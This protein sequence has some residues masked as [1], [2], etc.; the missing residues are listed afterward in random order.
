MR[1][2]QLNMNAFG[3]YSGKVS[4]DFTSF[5]GSSIFLVSG[6]TGAGKTTIF[7]ALAYALFDEA[8]GDSRDK[9]TFKSQFASDTDLCYVELEFELNGESYYIKRIP[10]QKGPGKTGK[11]I[12]RK[13]EVEFHHP[14][15]QT[16][17][18]KEANEEIE[19]LIG[20]TYEQF[21]QIVMLPQGQFKK[22]LESDSGDKEKIFRNIFKTNELEAFQKELKEKYSELRKEFEKFEH[23]LE[24][25]FK[26]I[27]I[28][29]SQ[30]LGKA[31]EQFETPQVLDELKQ[32]I[33]LDEKELD[34][35]DKQV[36]KLQKEGN[37][38]DRLITSLD[39]KNRLINELND[40]K[41]NQVLIDGYSEQLKAHE[42]AQKLSDLKKQLDETIKD[43]TKEEKTLNEN[44]QNLKVLEKQLEE[45]AAE[46]QKAETKASKLPEKRNRLADLNN[47]LQIFDR[48][49][50]VVTKKNALEKMIS[51]NKETIKANQKEENE[52][53]QE[54][55]NMEENLEKIEDWQKEK[56]NTIEKIHETDRKLDTETEYL[57]QV[58]KMKDQHETLLDSQQTMEKAEEEYKQA[59]HDY[60]K[61]KISYYNDL[62]GVLAT[63]LEV[64][65]PCPVCGSIHHPNAAG[66]S[67][68]NV[69]K[70]EY[71]HLFD[72]VSKKHGDYTQAKA[73][74]EQNAENLKIQLREFDVEASQLVEEIAKQEE[75]VQQ[76][77]DFSKELKAKRKQLETDLAKEKEWREALT[78]ISEGIQNVVKNINAARVEIEQKQKQM[79]ELEEER[80]TE[81]NKLHFDSKNDVTK[82][83][84]NV[85]KD[86]EEVEKN[87]KTSQ[88]QLNQLNNEKAS[89]DRTIEMTKQQIKTLTERKDSQRELFEEKLRKS[90]LSR[91]FQEKILEETVKED[92]KNKVDEHKEA[93]IKKQT[94]LSDQNDYLKT[95]D[96]LKSL[97]YYKEREKEIKEQLPNIQKNR[98]DV[99]NRL[100]QNQQ[101]YSEI[102]G[103]QKQSKEIEERVHTYAELSNYANGS[104]ETDYISFERYV[105]GIYFEE[106]LQAANIRFALMTNNRYLLERKIDKSKGAGPQ[107]L[108]INV[109][110][111]YTGKERNVNTLSGGETFK[112]SLSLALGLS[113]VIQSQN[114][115]VSVDTLFIDEGFGTLD[116]DSL[117][118]AIQTLLDLNK[119]GRLIGIISHVEELKTRIS[120]HII[121]EKTQVGSTAT[122]KT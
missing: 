99:L 81:T 35:L 7:D 53:L 47:E 70:E 8:S 78:Q 52:L 19:E 85:A 48:I 21:Q 83:I 115:G 1:P 36:F 73:R 72:R 105:L 50:Q 102:E 122:I 76:H 96:D 113:D 74:F 39:K 92:Y 93:L 71:D 77:E 29:G 86:I 5:Q 20:I 14:Y 82:A 23:S 69:T 75:L 112:A 107:G 12:N 101:A 9:D 2:L 45:T 100:R 114:G 65:D 38:L 97:G 26:G 116:S 30:K 108:D 6:P 109:F 121:V 16:T 90:D 111:H 61:A 42:Q 54:K 62:A 27:R 104:K 40:L 55:K 119:N 106:I 58:K 80:E 43:L 3:P 11:A 103:Y 31:I 4:L 120:S 32:N 94:Q 46:V 89:L 87:K 117:D 49:T 98:D 13:S 63:K 17:K 44:Q 64:N 110:D 59:D 15:G 51:E 95:I 28:N 24:Q 84:N 68:E 60:E 91:D 10:K 67:T 18:I 118:S 66:G 57:K 25:A 88:D 33:D 79:K 34:T 41:E 22:M 56:E 37:T